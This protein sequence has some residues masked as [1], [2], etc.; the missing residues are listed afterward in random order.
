MIENDESRPGQGAALSVNEQEDTPMVRA[1]SALAAF[2][3]EPTTASKAGMPSLVDPGVYTGD[4]DAF[5]AAKPWLA[6]VREY[7]E[8]GSAHPMAV[9]ALSLLRVSMTIPP[10]VVLPAFIGGYGSLNLQVCIVAKSGQ[11]KGVAESIAREVFSSPALAMVHE[12]TGGSGEGIVKAFRR[13][14][15]K[16]GDV[17]VIIVNEAVLFSFGE[18]DMLA[19]LSTRSGATLTSV[20]KSA[21]SGERLG[22]AYAD[23]TK[24]V[25]LPPHEYR[26]GLSVAIQPGK[27]QPLFD[28]TAG[29]APQ[30]FI[31]APAGG[32]DKGDWGWR[33]KPAPMRIEDQTWRGSSRLAIGFDPTIRDYVRNLHQAKQRE[34]IEVPEL[35]S[36]ATQTRMK[37]AA[38][39]AV[40]EGRRFV[41][42]EDW[43]LAG[44]FMD[45]SRE[46]RTGVV[47]HLRVEES[48]ANQKKGM[49]RGLQDAEA[50]RVLE[51]KRIMTATNTLRRKLERAQYEGVRG[52]DL[53]KALSSTQRELFEACG[54]LLLERG[55]A[56][57]DDDRVGGSRW[58]LSTYLP[59]G[60]QP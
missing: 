14:K 46:T 57:R 13:N 8:A 25:I 55:L 5:W 44:Y 42:L 59:L 54:E 22:N 40:I 48:R 9:L 53:K 2:L 24:A 60:V 19:A 7:A 15:V 39:M 12:V 18:G 34:L 49:A 51:G 43:A 16:D 45:R 10:H 37:V 30:R 32:W 47:E 29:G 21:Y 23:L 36:H 3:V 56:V 26:L 27:A 52:S 11:G 33:E 58:Y 31:W 28:D 41:D 20:L 1:E 50:E 35:E 6:H 38:I 4:E 17:E